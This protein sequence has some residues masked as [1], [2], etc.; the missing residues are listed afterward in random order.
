MVRDLI[1]W[2]KKRS[3]EQVALGHQSDHPIVTLQREMNELFDSF[4][5]EKEGNL[6]SKL[7]GDLRSRDTQGSFSIDVTESDKEVRVTADIP[8]VD[9]KDLDIEL[10]DNLLTIRGEKQQEAEEKES[11]YHVIERSWGSFRRSIPLPAGIETDQAK[12][13][14]RNGVLTVTLP[15]SAEARERRKL[16]PISTT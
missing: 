10:T 5:G 3:A 9:E 1:P 15:K 4:F 13:R 16:I 6:T 7:W 8:G 14:F 11:N 12:A 2:R